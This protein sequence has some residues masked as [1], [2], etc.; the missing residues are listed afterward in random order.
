MSW[1][2]IP[3]CGSSFVAALA[4]AFCPSIPAEHSAECA[5]NESIHQWTLSPTRQCPFHH[6]D[7]PYCNAEGKRPMRD[8][9]PRGVLPL[10]YALYPA[11]ARPRTARRGFS[12]MIMG[13]FTARLTRMP[14][15]RTSREW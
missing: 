5:L 11:A 13:R 4:G 8:A 15:T 14:T 9:M 6:G 10:Y 3:K 1:L 7:V 2:H 12:G